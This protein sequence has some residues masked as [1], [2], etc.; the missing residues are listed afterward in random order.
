MNAPAAA[1]DIED[2]RRAAGRIAPHAHRTPVMTGR[3]LDR[4][5]GATLLFCD[6]RAADKVPQ[7][8]VAESGSA[9][10]P[11]TGNGRGTP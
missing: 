3:S 8:P 5:T 6:L 11:A 9:G 2:V 10:P 1:P 7:S 4:E